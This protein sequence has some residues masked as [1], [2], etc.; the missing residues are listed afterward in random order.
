MTELN[1]RNASL[2]KAN[3]WTKNNV[4]IGL[5]HLEMVMNENEYTDINYMP[6]YL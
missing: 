2:T 1:Y 3:I 4:V 6:T 5:G